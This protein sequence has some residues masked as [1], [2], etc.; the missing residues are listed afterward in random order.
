MTT[1]NETLRGLPAVHR[2]YP[3]AGCCI[4]SAAGQRARQR[5]ISSISKPRVA[6]AETAFRRSRRLSGACCVV[7]Q[8]DALETLVPAINGTGVLLHTDLGRAPLA[9]SALDAARRIGEGYSNLE[10]DAYEGRRG[11]R[12]A[13]VTALL[14]SL[15]GAQDALVVN[16][17][18]AAVLLI[19]DTFAKGREVILAAINSS[20]SAEG[21]A[22]PTCWSAA[23]RAWWSGATSKVYAS[24]FQRALSPQTALL[25]IAPFELPHQRLHA[26]S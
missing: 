16:N 11:S 9:A 21:F 6:P 13:R 15:T 20:R 10:Y 22:F 17:C 8:R 2:F 1:N 19:L 24:D 3:P 26:R 12:Y 14:Q 18:A 4:R 25:L 7:L 5:S 23:A